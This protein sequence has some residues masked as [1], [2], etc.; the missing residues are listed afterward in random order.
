MKIVKSGSVSTLGDWKVSATCRNCK[1]GLVV[2][3]HDVWKACWSEGGRSRCSGPM[4]ECP[5]CGVDNGIVLDDVELF[6]TLDDLMPPDKRSW[7]MKSGGDRVKAPGALL[8]LRQLPGSGIPVPS[9]LLP[10]PASRLL[11]ACMS[12]LEAQFTAP[13]DVVVVEIATASDGDSAIAGDMEVIAEVIRRLEEKE[14]VVEVTRDQANAPPRA[15]R[16]KGDLQRLAH[17]GWLK[18]LVGTGSMV[19]PPEIG[20]HTFKRQ[21]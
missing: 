7:Q 9:V 3:I 19:E 2:G 10:S 18:G 6:Y 12:I 4:F 17:H 5:E 14:W 1:A 16:C 15:L 20:W 13:L 11:D 21:R 8:R